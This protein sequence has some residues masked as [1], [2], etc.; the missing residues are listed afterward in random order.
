MYKVKFFVRK[1]DEL[2]FAA[3]YTVFQNANILET[4]V[5]YYTARTE[6]KHFNEAVMRVRWCLYTKLR[7]KYGNVPLA[8]ECT[9]PKEDFL[10][11]KQ[12]CAMAAQRK[13]EEVLAKAAKLQPTLFAQPE[14]IEKKATGERLYEVVE[15]GGIWTIK[16]HDSKW[17]TADEA[18]TQLFAKIVNGD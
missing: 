7:T 5:Y 10:S 2:H 13:N 4:G 6:P 8:Q 9:N 18:K 16:K 15:V 12:M 17:Y 3:D 11:M 14:K 1:I